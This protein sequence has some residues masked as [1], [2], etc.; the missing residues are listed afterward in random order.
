MRNHRMAAIIIG[1][2]Y[3]I[4]TVTGVLSVVVT[5]PVMND[6]DPLARIAADATPITIG[7][8]LVLA[9][10][11]SLALVPVVFYPI[12]RKH[13]ELL[14]LGYL[15][16]RGALEPIA[17]IGIVIFSLALHPISIAYVAADGVQAANL[18]NLSTVL[19]ATRDSVNH[20]LIIIFSL[21]ALMLYTLLF[22]SRLVPRWLSIW[23]LIAIIMHLVTVFLFLFTSIDMFATPILVLNMPIFFQEMV[24]AV[25]LI[26]RGFNPA[27]INDPVMKVN[28]LTNDTQIRPAIEGAG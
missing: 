22:Q 12:A 3:I 16:F 28:T 23:G 1:A 5:T 18:Q 10:G 13:N 4:G 21:D 7:A 2:L 17:Y 9:M 27:V 20:I 6:P 11:L 14:A 8:L 24:M 19:L 25:W 26:V 15:I